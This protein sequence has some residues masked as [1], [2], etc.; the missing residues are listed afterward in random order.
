MAI[1]GRHGRQLSSSNADPSTDHHELLS[2]TIRMAAFH[3]SR[4]NPL[5]ISEQ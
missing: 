2:I 4:R 5:T 3:N 1:C